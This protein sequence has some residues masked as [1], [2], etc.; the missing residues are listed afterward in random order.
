MPRAARLLRAGVFAPLLALASFVAGGCEDDPFGLDDWEARP[1]TLLLY[2][3]ARPE[4]NLPSAVNLYRG[5]TV[6]V[7]SPSATGNW[8]LALDTDDGRLVFLTP[9]ALGVAS[10]ARIAAFPG[11]SY[12]DVRRAPSDTTSFAPA[13]QPVPVEL[14]TTYVIRTSEY[15]DLFGRSCVFYA[16]LQPLE[17]DVAAGTVRFM[18]DANPNCRELDLVPGG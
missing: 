18:T 7:E 11:M 15:R 13:E 2:S 12:D 17:A 6:V 8:D 9:L 1:D 14:G 3:L 4:L 10:Q 16:K 5:F